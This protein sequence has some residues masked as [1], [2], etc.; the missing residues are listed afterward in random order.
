MKADDPPFTF[1]FAL[2][3][4]NEENCIFKG[5]WTQLTVKFLS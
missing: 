2:A 5:D 4:T 3:Q 1:G